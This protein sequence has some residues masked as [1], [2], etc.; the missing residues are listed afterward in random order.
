VQQF[1]KDDKP[2]QKFDSIKAAAESVGVDGSTLIGAL[3]GWQKTSGG[4]KWKYL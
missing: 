3:K 1:S 4:Y 2:L